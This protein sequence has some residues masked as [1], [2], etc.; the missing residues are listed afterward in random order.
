[1]GEWFNDAERKNPVRTGF[2]SKSAYRNAMTGVLANQAF[3]ESAIFLKHFQEVLTDHLGIAAF[4][5]VALDEVKQ[6]TVLKQGN[7]R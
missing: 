7:G 1:M 6:F 3:G 4:D 5:V 2:S